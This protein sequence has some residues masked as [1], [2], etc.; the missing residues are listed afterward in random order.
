M[1]VSK[2]VQF[3]GSFAPPLDPAKVK[4]YAKL[5]EAMPTGPEEDAFG[6]LLD[7]LG[8]YHKGPKVRTNG[9]GS[10]HAS[11]R[12]VVLSLTDEEV[13]RLEE[14]VPWDHELD[15]YQKLFDELPVG[16]EKSTE[17]AVRNAAFH[18]LWYAK[19]LAMDREPMTTDKL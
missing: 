5:F 9:N 3:G 13:E 7:L 16:D 4:E 19:E 15:G 17:R 11:G 1:A 2:K 14:H 8:H 12:G 10:P 18:L 6:K